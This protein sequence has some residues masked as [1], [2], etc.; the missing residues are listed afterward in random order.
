MT[1]KASLRY[2]V[3]LSF[4]ILGLVVSLGLAGALYLLTID[5]EKRL[6]AETLTAELEDYIAR[7]EVDPKTS[8]PFSTTIR[9]YV[10]QSDAENVPEVLRDLN[11]GLHHVHHEGNSYYAEVRESGSRYFAVLYNDQQIR[12]RE[13]QFKFFLGFGVLMMT[14]ASALLGQWLAGRVIAPVGKL[15]ARVADFRPE[16]H[17]TPLA[18]DFP[19][20]EVGILAREFDAYLQRLAAFV[21]R[22][23]YFTAD[24][25]HELRTPL[26][27]I[28]GASEILLEDSALEEAQ[29]LRVERIAR[30]AKEMSELVKALLLLA[31]EENDI[32]SASGCAVEEVLQQTIENHRHLVRRKPVEIKLHIQTKLSLPVECPLLRVVLANLVRN[33]LCYTE[34][35]YVSVCLDEKGVSIKDTG[36]GISKAEI[37][38]IFDRYYT[39]PSGKEGIG[40]S[41]VKRICQ[42]Y[43]WNID[44]E[45]HESVGTTIRLSF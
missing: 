41:L 25:S 8:P 6:I 29:R 34:K 23:R 4:A 35:G 33:A 22:E 38:R 40:L 17:V 31:R 39:G 10:I 1:F 27:V 18:K 2:R 11:A 43:G 13:G 28:E 36:I 37:Q 20:G 45:S 16:N 7:L 14:L 15:A 24:V 30:S 21:E 26:S 9:T 44:I 3:S 42:R 19:Q 12:H 32:A 5:M